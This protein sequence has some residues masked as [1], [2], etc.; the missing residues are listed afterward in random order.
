MHQVGCRLN[1][2]LSAWWASSGMYTL[3]LKREQR[4]KSTISSAAGL[5][6]LIVLSAPALQPTDAAEKDYSKLLPTLA[7]T[8][9]SL[10]AGIKQG[11]EKSPEAAISAKFELDDGKLSLSVYTVEK[12]LDA[13]AEHNIL[14]ELA[15]SPEAS[16]WKPKVEVFE[17]VPHVSRASQ[18]LTLMS[19]SK[20][21]LLDI[22]AKAEKDQR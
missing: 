15:G 14:K 17:D 21:S 13:D 22:L 3:Y 5:A 1:A 8:K 12:G 19:L 10:A 16:E 20:L 11:A 6:L 2:R 4:M 18:Q 9:H 7:K